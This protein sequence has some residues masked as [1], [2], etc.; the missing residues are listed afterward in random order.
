MRTMKKIEKIGEHRVT[1]GVHTAATPTLSPSLEITVW[2]RASATVVSS[3]EIFS[4]DE[5]AQEDDGPQEAA[6]ETASDPFRR[7]LPIK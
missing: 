4:A 3:E 1:G 7:V 5:Q 2:C 6:M